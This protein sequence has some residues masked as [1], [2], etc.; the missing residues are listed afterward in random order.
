MLNKNISQ[1][2]LTLIAGAFSASIH[3]TE[4]GQ[5]APQFALPTLQQDQ[6]VTLSQ[7]SGKVVY[8]DFWASWC[9][10]CRT[11]FPLLN[12]LHKKLKSQGFEI[13]AINLDEDKTKAAQ[14]LKE[15]PVGF[16]VLTDA[17]GEWADKFVVESMPTSFIVDKL[18]VVQ[19][20]HHGFTA[21]DIT[22]LEKKITELLAKK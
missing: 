17:K 12:K 22:E 11:S 21:N 18:G 2:F 8:I 4:A 5:A 15:I 6:V 10:P 9:A 14:F 13:I 16:N 7:Y 1:I 3:A 19:H 20:V